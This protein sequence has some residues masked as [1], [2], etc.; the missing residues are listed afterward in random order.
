MFEKI[1]KF[2]S[3]G[4]QKTYDLEVN[5]K[6]HNFYANEICVGNS[7]S[8]SYSYTT[9]QTLWLKVYYPEYF[10]ANLL[11]VE[12]FD[13]Y[14]TIIADAI[15]N[16]IKI[17]FPTIN[18]AEYNFKAEPGAVRIGFKAL[19]GFGDSAQEELMAMNL[20]QY[21]N[22]YDI[23]ALP[24]KKVNSLA[25]NCLI[26][27]GAFNDFDIECEKIEVVR[28][29]Y[30][31]PTI[32]K[33]FTRD[34]N[35]LDI[36][37]VPEALLQIKEQHLLEAVEELRPV[38]IKRRQMIQQQ[39]I[40]FAIN[41]LYNKYLDNASKEEITIAVNNSLDDI[42]ITSKKAFKL[43]GIELSAL[44]I[45]TEE[46]IDYLTSIKGEIEDSLDESLLPQPWVLLINKI[47]PYVTFKRLTEK[48]KDERV[49]K[50]LGFSLTL[51]NNLSKLLTLADEYPDLN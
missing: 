5:S 47:I 16:G 21:D 20:N 10:Y 36:T 41:S 19:K 34:K 17:L 35:F 8:V 11:N 13:S 29:L 15:S 48:Q 37:T 22:I 7:H 3:L 46:T 23:L 2:E 45:P 42:K 43:I 44:D 40:N 26:D 38:E 4:K 33:W 51:V 1:I 31:D 28:N 24:F 9:M 25:F 18:K 32:I 50:V 30:K 27:A 12:P 49:E 14:Q 6:D 39:Q